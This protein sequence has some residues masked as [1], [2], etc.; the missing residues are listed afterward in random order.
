MNNRDQLACPVILHLTRECF[1]FCI[2]KKIS[3]PSYNS[4]KKTARVGEAHT[5]DKLNVPWAL[6]T[7]LEAVLIAEGQKENFTAAL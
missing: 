4:E 2:I 5:S 1:G 6:V 3:Y 7:R